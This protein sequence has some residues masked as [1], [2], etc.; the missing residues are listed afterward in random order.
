MIETQNSIFLKL[1]QDVDQYHTALLT[2]SFH[3]HFH[4]ILLVNNYHSQQVE[5]K[6]ARFYSPFENTL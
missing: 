1:I 3:A 4:L 6:C 2:Y 5:Y